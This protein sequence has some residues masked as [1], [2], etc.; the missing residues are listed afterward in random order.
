MSL[1]SPSVCEKKLVVLYVAAGG[2]HRAAAQ[3]IVEAAA[4]RGRKA[5]LV[6]ALTLT[7]PWFAKAYVG[8]HLRSTERAP[9]LYGQGYAALDRR[10]VVV[11]GV[12]G[13]FDRAVGAPLLRHLARE[14]PLA[15]IATHFFPLEILGHARRRGLL[16]APLVG[17]VTDYA[18]HAF[19]AEPGVD[20]FCAPAGRAARDLVRHGVSAD[21]VVATGIPIRR[22]FGAIAPLVLPAAE[23][24]GPLEVLVTSGGFGVGPMAEVVRGFAGVA[25]AGRVRL[26]IVCGD[27]RG[28]VAE[29]RSAAAV[30]GVSAEV[31]GFERDMASRIAR[32][33]VVVGKPGGLT[34]SECLAAG[35]PMVLVG[36]CPGQ[37]TMNQRWL[38]DQGAAVAADAASAGRAV[39]DLWA[40]A[41][42]APMGL[43]ARALSAPR[44]ADRVVDVALRVAGRGAELAPGFLRAA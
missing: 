32:S 26:T 13:A 27:N 39:A 23:G 8:A 22:G 25:N 31:V 28:R 34:V 12:R 7:P 6:D 14:R 37:E 43:E 30:A 18:A 35:R 42:L 24:G 41:L 10:H 17:V 1:S 16:D 15:I 20:R 9:G 44:A 36:A 5:E 21:A 3:A 2:G 38:V 40:R 4:A 19:W 29:A 11:D 33:H